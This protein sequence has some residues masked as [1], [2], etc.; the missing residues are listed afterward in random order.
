MNALA[1]SFLDQDPDPRETREWIESIEAVIGAEGT[2]RAH[3]I[4]E[5][6][7]DETRHVQQFREPRPVAPVALRLDAVHALVKLQRVADRQ[8]P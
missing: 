6:L 3:Q 1:Q 5:R 7:V 2:E 8:V 4:L